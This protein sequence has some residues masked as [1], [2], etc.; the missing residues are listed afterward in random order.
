MP[1]D[2]GSKEEMWTWVRKKIKHWAKDP[3]FR[4]KVAI[5]D[6]EAKH[7]EVHLHA[8]CLSACPAYSL[9]CTLNPSP[10]KLKTSVFTLSPRPNPNP[11]PQPIYPYPTPSTPDLQELQA[12]RRRASAAAAAYAACS[13]RPQIDQLN[14]TMIKVLLVYPLLNSSSRLCPRFC[15]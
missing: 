9:L 1:V 11:E 2:V 6:L 7:A 4:K 14:A 12:A 3:N 15:C 13:S 8:C 5:A 10:P